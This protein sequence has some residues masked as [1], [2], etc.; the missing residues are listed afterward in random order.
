[1]DEEER[2]RELELAEEK[3]RAD[4]WERLDWNVVGRPLI[5]RGAEVEPVNEWTMVDL[6]KRGLPDWE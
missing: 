3:W 2:W 5:L 1:M 4:N 6:V